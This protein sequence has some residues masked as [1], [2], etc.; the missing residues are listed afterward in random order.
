MK[1]LIQSC[2]SNHVQFFRDAFRKSTRHWLT[3][4]RALFLD[5]FN[6]KLK[7]DVDFWSQ[8]R[9]EW[10]MGLNHWQSIARRSACLGR[11]HC[12]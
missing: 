2:P 4:K 6:Q 10:S 8:S 5:P 3:A 1:K 9:K 11:I 7:K 12:R